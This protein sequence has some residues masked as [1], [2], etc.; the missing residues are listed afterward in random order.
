VD[1]FPCS[2]GREFALIHAEKSNGLAKAAATANP[3][4]RCFAGEE[5][6]YRTRASPIARHRRSGIAGNSGKTLASGSRCCY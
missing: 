3:V 1:L 5:G 6:N 2:G 4:F